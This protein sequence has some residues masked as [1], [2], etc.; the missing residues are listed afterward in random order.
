M[1]PIEVLVLAVEVKPLLCGI[2]IDFRPSL[3]SKLSKALCFQY[4]V[5]RMGR[6]GL[7][8]VGFLLELFILDFW[9]FPY[10]AI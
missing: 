1:T 5:D 10:I 9:A 2:P 3:C 8:K 4:P 6:V 7:L